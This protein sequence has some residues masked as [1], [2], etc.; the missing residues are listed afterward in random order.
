MSFARTVAHKGFLYVL[1]TTSSSQILNPQMYC[2]VNDGSTQGGPLM[3]NPVIHY[4][5][6]WWTQLSV[7]VATAA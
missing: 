6:I 2:P 5:V 7:F 1:R 4:D 3:K